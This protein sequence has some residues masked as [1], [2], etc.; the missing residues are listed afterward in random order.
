MKIISERC[1]A[2]SLLKTTAWFS[3][4]MIY[5]KCILLAAIAFNVHV[6]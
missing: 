2:G 3:F 5:S 6:F 4:V 1:H